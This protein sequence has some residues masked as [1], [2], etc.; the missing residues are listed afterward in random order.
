M[1]KTELECQ[2]DPHYIKRQQSYAGKRDS[3]ISENMRATLVDWIVQV[4]M[5]FRLLPETLFIAVNL[6]DR[7]LSVRMG[8]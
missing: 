7:F 5:K 2:P 3:A 4:H 1:Q 6:I 8:I